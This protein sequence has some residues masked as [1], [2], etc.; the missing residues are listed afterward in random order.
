VLAFV[1]W[2][3]F[4]HIKRSHEPRFRGLSFALYKQGQVVKGA[5]EVKINEL[6]CLLS[7]K[8]GWTHLWFL[9]EAKVINPYVST[10]R[11][12]ADRC[13]DL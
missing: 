4:K 12:F 3:K 5:I 9:R 10:D 8:H 1:E 7:H 13:Y 2:G 6:V 11:I